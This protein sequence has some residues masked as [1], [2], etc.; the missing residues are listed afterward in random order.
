[1]KDLFKICF[2]NIRTAIILLLSL[3]CFVPYFV[4][5]GN[6]RTI[7]YTTTYG[8]SYHCAGCGSLWNSSYPHSLVSVSRSNKKPCHCCHPPR[9]NFAWYWK[10]GFLTC[11]FAGHVVWFI[12][13]GIWYIIR[14][15]FKSEQSLVCSAGVQKGNSNPVVHNG[16]KL[17]YRNKHSGLIESVVV[18][19]VSDN[20]FGFSYCG[21]PHELEM[22]AIGTR[23]FK[24]PNEISD[25]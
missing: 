4:D 1:M 6:S 19:S 25:K 23:L 8:S 5:I 18:T 11:F 16:Q 10:I 13:Y 14:R 2:L 3:S 22:H 12:L 24:S 7:V 15:K 9:P 17:W 21:V 20:K